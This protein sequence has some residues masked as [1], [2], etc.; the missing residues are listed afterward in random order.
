MQ[1]S[2]ALVPFADGKAL[3][4]SSPFH[5]E[6]IDKV[7]ARRAPAIGQHSDAILR[8]AGYSEDEIAGLRG[9]GVVA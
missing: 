4:V 2:G 3:T 5:L 7:P 6:G 9:S 1:D 8:D